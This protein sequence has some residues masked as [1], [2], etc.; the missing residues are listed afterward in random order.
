MELPAWTRIDPPV[1]RLRWVACDHMACPVSTQCPGSQLDWTRNGEI[2]R[3]DG[4]ASGNTL[5][6]RQAAFKAPPSAT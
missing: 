3:R 2:S 5:A 4:P 6:P 1:D